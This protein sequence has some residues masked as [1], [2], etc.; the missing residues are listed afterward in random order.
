MPDGA[1]DPI[2]SATKGITKGTYEHIEEKLDEWMRKFRQGD[3]AFIEDEKTV[4]IVR[5]QRRKPSWR[6]FRKYVKN[7]DIRLQIEMGLSLKALDND[8]ERLATLKRKIIA[9]FGSKGLHVAELSQVGLIDKYIWL[10]IDETS[11]EKDLHDGVEEIFKDIDRY[12]EFV[13]AEQ[14]ID[15]TV[16]TIVTR[17]MSL[18]PR[19]NIILCRGDAAEKNAKQILDGVV[20]EIDGYRVEILTEPDAAQTCIFILRN[21]AKSIF[22]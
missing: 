10:L 19:A 11:D 8:M 21:D 4:E 18:K 12:V 22:E 13:K 7:P 3:L 17:I 20:K 1:I 6:I 16:K 14:D 15:R 9:K 2:E 5:S